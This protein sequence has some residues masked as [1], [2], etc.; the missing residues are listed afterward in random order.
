MRA[1]MSEKIVKRQ[2]SS[3][4]Q[5]RLFSQSTKALI[6]TLLLNLF[7]QIGPAGLMGIVDETVEV[8]RHLHDAD[9]ATEASEVHI[10]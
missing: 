4:F 8:R 10:A 3:E 6:I 1:Q 9:A 7:Q 2:T 5:F